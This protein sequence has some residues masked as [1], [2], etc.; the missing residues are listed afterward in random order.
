MYCSPSHSLIDAEC[1]LDHLLQI[2]AFLVAVQVDLVFRASLYQE[3]QQTKNTSSTSSKNLNVRGQLCREMAPASHVRSHP[4]NSSCPSKA[5]HSCM[6]AATIVCCHLIHFLPPGASAKLYNGAHNKAKANN[7]KPKA[8]QC[9]HGPH[10]TALHFWFKCLS[11]GFCDCTHQSMLSEPVPS[12]GVPGPLNGLADFGAPG[13][14]HGASDAE[15]FICLI[16]ELW[17]Q[18]FECLISELMRKGTVDLMSKM[19]RDEHSKRA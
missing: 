14:G 7:H 9:K 18:M 1:C 19:S 2:C 11:P 12:G 5:V 13:R 17:G 8:N 3:D 4:C 6:F 16:L 15:M 10:C